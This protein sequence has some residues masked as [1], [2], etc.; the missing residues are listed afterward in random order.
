M[1]RTNAT[2]RDPLLVA[3]NPGAEPPGAPAVPV[4]V[5]E[6]KVKPGPLEIT[7][8]RRYAILSGIWTATFLSSLNTTL[9]A[10]LLSSISS[11]FERSNQASWLGTAY[12]LATCTFTPLYGRLCNVMGRRGANQLA[13][14]SAAVGTLACGLS[15]NMEMLIIARF[16]SGL[17]GGGINTTSQIIVSDMYTIRSRGLA[18]GVA[19][20]FNGLGMGLGGPIGGYISDRYGWR[21]AFLIQTPLFAASLFLTGMYL[22]YV[23]PGRG[24]SAREV[25]SRVDYGGTF[26]LLGAVLAFLVFLS[27]KFNEERP[28]SVPLVYGSLTVS[29]ILFILFVLVELLVAPEPVL[30][31]FLLRQKIPVLIGVQNFLVSNCNFAVMYFFPMWFETVQLTS[32]STAGAHLLPNSISMSCGSLFAGYVMHRTGRYKKINLIFGILPFIAAISISMLR[33]DS[34]WFQSWFSIIPL[35]FGNAV[36]LQT[37]LIALLAHIPHSVMAVGTGFGQLFRG[38][39]QVAGVGIASSIFQSLLDKELNERITVPDSEYW[40]TRIRHSAKLVATLPPELQRGA[41]DSYAI[42]LRAVFIYASVSTLM[43]YLVRLLIPDKALEDQRTEAR[44]KSSGYLRQ[45]VVPATS[46]ISRPE[47]SHTQEERQEE[48]Q[49]TD[50]PLEYCESEVEDDTRPSNEEETEAHDGEPHPL[51]SDPR[52]IFSKRRRLSTFES[53]DGILDL[54]SDIIGGSARS[55]DISSVRTIGRRRSFVS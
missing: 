24:K 8:L 40:I 50:N 49:K 2:E 42:A 16:L 3:S 15:Q 22:N 43:A 4:D 45:P 39:G 37:T 1:S 18:Q 27:N 26:T 19:N 34:N 12:L 11:E 44:R 47:S 38:I 29:I 21:W 35:G 25:L 33:A 51:H 30:A 10:T 52:K 54:E 9:V 36:V 5:R 48:L 7:R 28:W 32:A 41:R 46:V 20:I 17:G 6:I 31:P 13:V 23:T 55:F 14:A 53:N